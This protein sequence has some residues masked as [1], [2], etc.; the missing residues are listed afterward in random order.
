MNQIIAMNWHTNR[1]YRAAGVNNP[2]Q[3]DLLDADGNQLT[4]NG[5]AGFNDNWG[6][7]CAR[8]YDLE[9]ANSAPYVSLELETGDYIFDG[10][11]RRD[12]VQ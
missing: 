2:A 10:S 7:C 12:T 8:Q 4:A 1:N 3:L 9:Y 6:D 5:L 11:V